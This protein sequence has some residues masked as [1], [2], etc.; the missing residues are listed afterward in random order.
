LTCC[1][2]NLRVSQCLRADPSIEY[3]EQNRFYFMCV[4]CVTTDI[5]NRGVIV[6]LTGKTVLYTTVTLI[7]IN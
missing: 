6:I 7:G 1:D 3:L 4:T 2:V 5:Q